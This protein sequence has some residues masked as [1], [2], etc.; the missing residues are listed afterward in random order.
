MAM[1]HIAA[2]LDSLNDSH[3]FFLPP[4]HAYLHDFG[5]QYQMIGERCSVTRVRPKSDAETKGVKPGDEVPTING[6]T[7]TR[8]TLWKLQYVF[9]VLRPQP[10]LLLDFEGSCGHATSG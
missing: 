6:F 3:T 5:W 9:R 7:P 8:Q 1:S 4:Q 10:E 2:A